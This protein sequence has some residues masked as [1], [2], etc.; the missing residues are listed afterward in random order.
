MG[1]DLV[2]EI[3]TE[4]MPASAVTL[5]INQL[6]AN[7]SKSFADARLTYDN[8]DVTGTPR[9]LVLYGKKLA[10][11]QGESH[12]E[13]RGPARAAAFDRNFQPS[14][15]AYGF[16]KAQGIRVTDLE[17]KDTPRGEYVFA[18]KAIKPKKATEIL[19]D[20]LKNLV[21]SFDFPKSM[22]WNHGDIRFSRPIR[23]ILALFGDKVIDVFLEGIPSGNVTYGHRLLSKGPLRVKDAGS[24]HQVIS[25]GGVVFDYREREKIIRD[26]IE[27]IAVSVGGKPVINPAVLREVVHLVEAPRAITGTF[28]KDFLALPRSVL[29]TAME[30]HQRYFPVEDKAGRLLNSFIVVHNGNA[31]YDDLI[32]RGHERVIRARLSDAWFFFQE[33]MKEPFEKRVERLQGIAFQEKLGNLYDKTLRVRELAG[34]IGIRLNLS[35]QSIKDIERGAYLC[36]ADLTTQMVREFPVLQ[37]I[38]G[39]EYAALSGEKKEVSNVISEHYLPRFVGDDHPQSAAGQVVSIADKIDT[40]VGCFGIDLVPT[41]SEDPYALRRQGQAVVAIILEKKLS[42]SFEE[43]ARIAMDLYHL[44]GYK[45]RPAERIQADLDLFFKQRLKFHFATEAF[46]YDVV[47]VVLGPSLNNLLDLEARARAINKHLGTRTM[48]DILTGFERCYNLSKGQKRTAVRTELFETEAEKALY[49]VASKGAADLKVLLAERNVDRGLKLLATLRPVVDRF[50]DEVLVMAEE[51]GLRQ[52]RLS[53]LLNCVD[54]Y[55]SV[56]DFSKIVREGE[57]AK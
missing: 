18:L 16:A 11:K 15:A 24:Y 38:I 26:E 2:F 54:L 14:A 4:E 53:L 17:I 34:Q 42:L 3:G 35:S 36:K 46:R 30:S 25:E 32:S 19:P 49:Q 8:L 21:L 27:K 41:G 23:W 44:G 31:D 51:E 1:K 13:I 56:A 47:E 37:G 57:E 50:F 33:D 6:K 10:E 28:S 22:R 55:L 45:L 40:I 39:Q 48:D 12:E 43:I 52:N 29:T 5:G 7:A 20:I 9:R